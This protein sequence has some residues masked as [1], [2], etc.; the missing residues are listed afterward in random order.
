MPLT[1]V[2]VC[3]RPQTSQLLLL[4]HLERKIFIELSPDEATGFVYKVGI[5]GNTPQNTPGNTP[6]LPNKVGQFSKAILLRSR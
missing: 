3:G 2:L 6:R 4:M 5:E 1:L